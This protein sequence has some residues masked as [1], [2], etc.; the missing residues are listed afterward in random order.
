LHERALS[1]E[2]FVPEWVVKR[3]G[4]RGAARLAPGNSLEPGLKTLQ[5]VC[6]DR[7]VYTHASRDSPLTC[8]AQP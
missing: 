4:H 2:A 5:S 1:V 7:L 3:V 6:S 8:L